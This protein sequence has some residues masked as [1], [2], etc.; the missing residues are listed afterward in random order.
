M[1]KCVELGK[2]KCNAVRESF[3]GS[4][5]GMIGYHYVIH[6]SG[7]SVGELYIGGGMYGR[8]LKTWLI[9]DCSKET[10]T[11]PVS[12]TEAQT[13]TQDKT[14]QTATTGNGAPRIAFEFLTLI[15]AVFV[16][17]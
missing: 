8:A 5:K 12:T 2:T 4:Q 15:V 3:D 10:T 1:K 6:V 11:K 14:T 16:L 7:L 17:G 13:T 9:D